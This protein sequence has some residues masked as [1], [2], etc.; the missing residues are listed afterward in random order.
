MKP[1]TLIS[2]ENFVDLLILIKDDANVIA[3][4]NITHHFSL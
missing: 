1:K 4:N 3:D 2:S